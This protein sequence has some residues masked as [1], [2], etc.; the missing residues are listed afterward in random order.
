MDTQKKTNKPSAK[1][2]P[3]P[4]DFYKAFDYSKI[5]LLRSSPFYGHFI[6]G[7][8]RIFD[9]RL[10]APAGVLVKDSICLVVNP[11]LFMIMT[12][13]QRVDLLKHEVGHLLADHLYRFDLNKMES[14]DAHLANLATDVT[15]N[16][17]LKSLHKFANEQQIQ[18]FI[19]L[20]YLKERPENYNFGITYNRLREKIP[21]LKDNQ[22]AEYYFRKLKENREEFIKEGEGYNIDVGALDSHSEWQKGEQD[23]ET[24]KEIIKQTAKNAKEKSAGRIPSELEIYLED[25]FKNSVNWKRELRQFVLKKVRN[26]KTITRKKRNRRYGAMFP[27]KKRKPKFDLAFVMDTSASVSDEYLSQMFAEAKK[28]H[29]EGYHLTLIEASME[30]C[31][32]YEFDPKK[33]LVAHGRGGTA[34]N[35][36]LKRAEELG[37]DAIIYLGDGGCIES[38]NELYKPKIPV[39]WCMT[40]GDRPPANWGKYVE[41]KLNRK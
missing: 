41:M 27:G 30:V 21:D 11:H 9:T 23:K 1:N 35:P 5:C 2:L 37:V 19:K 40:E 39:M 24:I 20:G 31:R 22:S 12:P 33:P 36:G 34:Y 29:N 6:I 26:E 7:T 25:L 14:G 13:Q 8:K 28:L 18:E 16:Q 32:E 3:I 38:E 10:P 4:K 15:I 17:P